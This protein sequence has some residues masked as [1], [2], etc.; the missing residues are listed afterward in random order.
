MR[1]KLYDG[2]K[3]TPELAGHRL[4]VLDLEDLRAGSVLLVTVSDYEDVLELSRKLTTLKSATPL[5][6]L[7]VIFLRE[8]Q[9]MEILNEADMN[10]LGWYR[11]RT[12][13]EVRGE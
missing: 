12:D 6:P 5:P 4:Q 10:R 2:A 8:G 13:G 3:G 11:R 1:P 7:P 9:G